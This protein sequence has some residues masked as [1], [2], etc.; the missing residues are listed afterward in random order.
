MTLELNLAQVDSE[1]AFRMKKLGFIE[2]TEDAKTVLDANP[3][4]L[5]TLFSNYANGNYGD[6]VDPGANDIALYLEEGQCRAR[7]P[8]PDGNV[9]VIETVFGKPVTM[10]K[11]EEP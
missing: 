7:Y 11:V 8:M 3:I 9:L 5:M 4:E 2:M 1:T 10:I 6:V